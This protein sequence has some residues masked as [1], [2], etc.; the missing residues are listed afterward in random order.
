L[1]EVRPLKHQSQSPTDGQTVFYGV[2]KA[3]Q[4]WEAWMKAD[5]VFKRAY[6]E[7]V[8]LVSKLGASDRLQPENALS[9]ELGVSRTTV[10]KV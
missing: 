6:N 5:M 8:D 2:K 4:R 1:L 10:R 9:A 7:A 3:S